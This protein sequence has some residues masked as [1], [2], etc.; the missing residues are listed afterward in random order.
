MLTVWRIRQHTHCLCAPSV[1]WT[2]AGPL[3][4]LVTPP[5]IIS[6]PVWMPMCVWEGESRDDPSPLLAMR[7]KK[8]RKGRVPLFKKKKKKNEKRS[9]D[10]KV[11]TLTPIVHRKSK[12]SSSVP[13]VIA[14]VFQFLCENDGWQVKFVSGEWRWT[15]TE[16]FVLG[17]EG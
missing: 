11:P 2:F 4:L 12:S 15:V 10:V 13:S 5:S 7:H 1:T 6:M 17:M 8:E 9:F 16:W 14:S 3:T